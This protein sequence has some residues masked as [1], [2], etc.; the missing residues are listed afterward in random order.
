MS[1]TTTSITLT[2]TLTDRPPV[3]IQED[4]WP[5]IALGSADDDDSSH[6]GHQPSREWTRTIRVRQHTDGRVLVYGI[7]DYS[8][9]WQGANGAAA[10]RGTLLTTPTPDQIITEI[11]AVGDELAAAEFDAA[12]E[13]SRKDSRQWHVAVQ[14]CIA[15][16]P[17]VEL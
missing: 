16:L 12:I 14:A 7:Y 10:R 6:S 17:A 9:A 8:T 13:E 1:D 5:V 3:K 4:E 11:R 15:D 2:I